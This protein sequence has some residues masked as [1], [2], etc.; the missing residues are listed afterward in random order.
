MKKFLYELFMFFVGLIALILLTI[1]VLFIVLCVPFGGKLFAFL[2]W[3]ALFRV[4]AE[5]ILRWAEERKQ[6]K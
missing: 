6:K 1:T 4:I 5:L 2:A 3:F